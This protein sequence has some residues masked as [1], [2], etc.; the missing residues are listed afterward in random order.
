VIIDSHAHLWQRARNPQPWIDSDTMRAIDRDFWVEDLAGMQAATGIDGAIVVQAINSLDETRDL[1]AAV[2]GRMIRGV[3]GWVDLEGDVAAQLFSLGDGVT[4]SLVGI[5][6]L[7]HLDPD[8]DWLLRP[9]VGRGLEALADAG[10]PFDLVVRPD[11]LGVA[12]AVVAEHPRVAF[13]V[14]HLGKP[15]IASGAL[16]RWSSDLAKVAA[17]PQVF[18]KLS[19]L[20]IEADWRAWSVDDLRPV[21]DLALE[22]FGPDRLLFGSDWPLVELT[23]GPASWLD[24]ARQLVD[25]AHH[26]AVFGDNALSFYTP[27]SDRA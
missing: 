2:D 9:A 14:D 18:A 16:E 12:A 21:V 20:T 27:R 4:G 22:V 10:L 1:L 7:A 26:D 19:G 24:V 8:P 17:H 13:V 15:P 6:H 25:D 11:Q 3:V 5:R 23:G